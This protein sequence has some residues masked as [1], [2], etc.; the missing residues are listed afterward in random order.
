[1]QV[2]S[3]LEVSITLPLQND[4]AVCVVCGYNDSSGF[5]TCLNVYSALQV[6]STSEF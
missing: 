4:A 6:G 2:T 5:V 3:A 1:M